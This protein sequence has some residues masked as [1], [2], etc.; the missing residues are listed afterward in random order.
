MLVYPKENWIDGGGDWVSV[1]FAVTFLD[2]WRTS[3]CALLLLN[4]PW[5]TPTLSPLHFAFFPVH[6]ASFPSLLHFAFFPYICAL[7]L[8]L[9]FC[10][11][12]LPLQ[13]ASFYSFLHCSSF[14]FL[15]L[16]FTLCVLPLPYYNIP[17][18]YSNMKTYVSNIFETVIGYKRHNFLIGN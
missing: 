17:W 3:F 10:D 8:P 9:T 15:S 7:P 14:P 12:P 11:F 5:Y 1:H 2:C 18:T 6:Y 16:S 13:W 4:S